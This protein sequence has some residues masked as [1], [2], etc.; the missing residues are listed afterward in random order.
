MQDRDRETHELR[1]SRL[2]QELLLVAA[3]QDHGLRE[4]TQGAMLSGA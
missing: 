3:E 4:A 2:S 1:L